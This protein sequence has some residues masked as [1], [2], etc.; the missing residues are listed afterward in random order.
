ME[1]FF[2]LNIFNL[3]MFF[4]NIKMLENVVLNDKFP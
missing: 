3:K 2:H 4:V 1:D